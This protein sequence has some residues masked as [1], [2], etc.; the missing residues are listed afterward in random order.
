MFVLVVSGDCVAQ[1]VALNTVL[2]TIVDLFVFFFLLWPLCFLFCGL[3]I[4]I[5]LGMFHPE[6]NCDLI[7]VII[8]LVIYNRNYVIT[9]FTVF[10]LL[11][12]CVCLY[13]DEF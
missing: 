1:C 3:H 10:R 12:D 8:F 5:I 6:N 13:T 11:T 7:Y 9:V 2:L 4:Q